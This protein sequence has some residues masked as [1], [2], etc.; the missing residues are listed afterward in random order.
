M[1]A[2]VDVV[3]IE[4]DDDHISVL[5]VPQ[6][7]YKAKDAL[8]ASLGEIEFA[9]LETSYLPQMGVTLNAED[10]LAFDKLLAMLDEVEDVA[11][12]FHNVKL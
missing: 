5:T 4:K 2:E 8:E 9:Q 12:I 3:D 11:N 6:D 1:D 7:L 10:Q